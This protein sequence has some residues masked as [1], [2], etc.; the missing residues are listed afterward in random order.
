MRRYC[1]RAVALIVA[2][3]SSIGCAA[4]PRHI[5]DYR[6][7]QTALVVESP[8][9]DVCTIYGDCG[10]RIESTTV[11]LGEPIGFTLSNGTLRAVA[12]DDRIPLAD[13]NYSW[14]V[15]PPA[16][17]PPTRV[18]GRYSP[19]RLEPV[20]GPQALTEFVLLGLGWVGAAAPSS[21]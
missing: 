14:V 5:V 1:V 16:S 3:L 6:S 4:A 17:L 15:E 9:R 2:G 8:I 19:P 7:G 21:Q 11:V 13:G 10:Q 20:T 18:R 12:G